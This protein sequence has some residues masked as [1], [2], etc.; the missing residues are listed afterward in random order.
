[1]QPVK[2]NAGTVNQNTLPFG[3]LSEKASARFD[4]MGMDVDYARGERLFVE[5]ETPRCVFVLSRGRIKVSVTSREGKTMILKIAE[6]GQVLGLS[7][8]LSGTDHEVTAEA[9]EPCTIKAI[10]T[11]D[12]LAF[13]Q[14]YPDASME[15]TRCVLREYQGI[16]MDVC[17]LGLP[18]TVAGRLAGLLLNWPKTG[19]Q[20][21]H[22]ERR[23]I[24]PLTREEIAGMAATSRETVSRILNQFEREKLICVKGSSVTVLQPEALEQLAM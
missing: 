7:A 21:G 3:D 10:P 9:L 6:A 8:A 15:A 5:G 18:S 22:T 12:F 14:K 4:E 19:L 13:L 11:K 16:F 1:M 17:R 2:V 24:V 20:T 23:F